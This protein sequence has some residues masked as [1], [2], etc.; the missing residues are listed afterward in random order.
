MSPKNNK[1]KYSFKSKTPSVKKRSGSGN[2]LTILLFL[3][4]FIV[5]FSIHFTRDLD[6]TLNSVNNKVNQKLSLYGVTKEDV[7]YKGYEFKRFMLFKVK[8]LTK[9]YEVPSRISFDKIKASMKEISAVNK[10]E[11]QIQSP[12]NNLCVFLFFKYNFLFYRLELY[13]KPTTKKQPP[14]IKRPTEIPTQPTKYEKI[15]IAIVLDDWGYNMRNVEF[16]S[17]IKRPVTLAVLPGLSNS[18]KIAQIGHNQGMEIILHMPMESVGKQP[19]YEKNTIFINMS[20]QE[21]LSKLRKSITEVPFISGVSNHQ[22]SKITADTHVMNIV[23]DELKKRGLYF[24]D[25]LTNT[26]SVA[27]EVASKKNIRCFKRDVFLDDNSDEEYIRNQLYSLFEFAKRN[28]SAV[29]IGHDRPNTI[30]VLESTMPELE[31]QGVCFVKVSEL[32]E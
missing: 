21:V 12:N 15:P 11:V 20:D 8:F 31:K 13:K 23:T 7:T 29:G 19:Q 28:G 4:F 32:D 24:L 22:G 18:K 17:N 14:K 25:S 10:S 3:S 16:I 9:A 5:M 1:Q 30:K 6:K 27:F 2:L 26:K